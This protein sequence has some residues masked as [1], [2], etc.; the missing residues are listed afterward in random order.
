MNDHT[1]IHHVPENNAARFDTNLEDPGVR[2]ALE[3]LSGSIDIDHLEIC[4]LPDA[5]AH[6]YPDTFKPH[7]LHRRLSRLIKIL[8]QHP[9]A[10][11]CAAGACQGGH[12][13]DPH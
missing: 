8:G 2:E 9:Q 4:F 13:F 5:T 10:I 12:Y 11:R 3:R 1:L 7:R 6:F